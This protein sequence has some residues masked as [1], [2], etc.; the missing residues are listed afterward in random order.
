MPSERSRDPLVGTVVNGK[1]LVEKAIARGGM[2]RIYLGRQRPLDRPVALKIVKDDSGEEESRFIERFVLEASI[3]AKLQHPNVV[4]I[5]DYGR[6]EGAAVETYFIAMEYLAGQTLSD[7]LRARG[8]LPTADALVLFRQMA[9]GLRE[10]HARGILHRDLKPS[11]ILLVPDADGELVKIV[12]FGIG[13]IER[14]GEDLTRD[15][16][17]V[18][19]PKYM[20]PEQ[21][22]GASSPA[23]DVHALGTIFYQMVTGALPF[24]GGS[25]LELMYSKLH[26]AITPM[27]EANPACDASPRVEHLVHGMLARRPEERPTLDEVFG[28]LAAC[29]QEVFGSARLAL[30]GSRPGLGA[31]VSAASGAISVPP[32]FVAGGRMAS[33]PPT[34]PHAPPWA[35]SAP[36]TGPHA[37]PW[38]MPAPP[39]GPHALPGTMSA[40]PTGI[41]PRPMARPAFAQPTKA[42]SPAMMA[43]VGGL[44]AAMLAVGAVALWLASGRLHPSQRTEATA[45]TA[46]VPSE[47]S[48]PD[49]SAWFTLH[50]DSTPSGAEVLADDGSRLGVTPLEVP[51]ERARASAEERSFVL[52]KDGFVTTS[53]RQGASPETRVERVVELA[54][55]PKKTPARPAGGA[56]PVPTS[57]PAADRDIRLKR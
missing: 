38:A 10:A 30:T 32:A 53:L 44:V 5:F 17:L 25:T 18:G 7:R 54:P 56:R 36:P 26:A 20:A 11:N 21:F 39:T 37:P 8:A 2:G 24:S 40:P 28:L 19:T 29:E 43:I 22:E 48:A 27:H 57:A 9:R 3:L 1:F 42:R 31:S 51:I 46:S 14:G 45:T 52:K 23:T 6:I 12:D 34:G 41:T 15:G 16:V 55:E 49:A 33:G 50:I 13:K 35:T 4:T 47:P